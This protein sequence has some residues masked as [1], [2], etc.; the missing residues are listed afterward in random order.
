MSET[1]GSK[2]IVVGVD[3]SDQ[4]R[5]ALE[6][7]I[8]EARLRGSALRVVY[9]FPALRGWNTPISPAY[10][11][12]FESD[13]KAMLTEFLGG[14]PALDDLPDVSRLVVGGNAATVLVDLSGDADLLVVGSRGRGGFSS[15]VLGSVSTQSVHH[16]RCPVVVVPAP[17]SPAGEE[18]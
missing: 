7:A 15:L 3:G 14:V 1:S 2:G 4:S 5:A 9:V 18:S 13:A 16:A 17:E 10:Y 12:Q 8:E 11:E 6:W